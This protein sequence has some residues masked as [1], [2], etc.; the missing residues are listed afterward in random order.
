MSRTGI[1]FE[2]VKRAIAELQG[3]QKNPTVDNIREILGTGSKS[4]IARFLREWKAQQGLG[5]DNDCRLPSDLLGIVNGLWGALQG[6]ANTQMQQ[7]R[8]EFETN[9]F[10]IQQ[11]LTKARQ[12]E[13]GLQQS[14][15]AL[16]EQLHQQKEEMQQLKRRLVIE[17]QEKIRIT[18][19]AD[20][21]KSRC[22]EH[23]AENLRLHQLLKQVQANLEHYQAATQ[24][25]RQEQS[26]ILEKQQNE[27]E[28]RLSLLLAQTNAATKEKT[29]YQAQYE[30]L[31]K[32]YT[33]LITEHKTLKQEN[34]KIHKQHEIL[35]IM[36]DKFHCDNEL[37]KDQ[38][39]TQFSELTAIQQIV[40]ELKLN[41]T[42]RNENIASLEAAIKGATNK[43]ETLRQ[44]SQFVLQEKANLEGQLQQMQ[45]MLPSKKILENIRC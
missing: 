35:K 41:V 37:L 44:E 33:A 2:E 5:S 15:H 20:S 11:Q 26:I 43:I 8:I 3:R 29:A 38:N 22:Q 1:T 39:K 36:H 31:E 24:K 23:H 13:I 16:E 19:R 7:C 30:Q 32:V 10:Q 9:S 4:T 6:K 21:F 45:T 25:L 18:E 28:Q 17:S 14:I 12:Q 40:I 34:I 42:S 27:S